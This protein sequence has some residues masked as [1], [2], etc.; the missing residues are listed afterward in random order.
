MSL[1]K[2][3]VESI[4]LAGLLVMMSAIAVATDMVV[5]EAKPVSA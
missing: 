5:V 1:K 3:A 2:R 4:A